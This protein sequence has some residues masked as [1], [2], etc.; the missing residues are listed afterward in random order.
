MPSPLSRKRGSA[1]KPGLNRQRNFQPALKTVKSLVDD[2]ADSEDPEDRDFKTKVLEQTSQS[3][4]R[5]ETA[6]TNTS[7]GHESA[8]KNRLQTISSDSYFQKDRLLHSFD[9]DSESQNNEDSFSEE[10]TESRVLTEVERLEEVQAVLEERIKQ[11]KELLE[12]ADSTRNQRLHGQRKLRRLGLKVQKLEQ[13]LELERAGKCGWT[14]VRRVLRK[15][16]VGFHS[17]E[18]LNRKV[19]LGLIA[20][21]IDTRP[22]LTDVVLQEME[23]KA[24]V[25]V[26][27]NS[28][29]PKKLFKSKDLQEFQQ[30]LSDNQSQ[31]GNNVEEGGKE[32]DNAVLRGE[33]AKDAA[34]GWLQIDSSEELQEKEQRSDRKEMEKGWLRISDK[35]GDFVKRIEDASDTKQFKEAWVNINEQGRERFAR[36][37]FRANMNGDSLLSLTLDGSGGTLN[38]RGEKLSIDGRRSFNTSQQ[39][40]LDRKDKSK[41]GR[42]GRISSS[43]S[44]PT[45]KIVKIQNV[46]GTTSFLPPIPK[47]EA[48]KRPKEEQV[49]KVKDENDGEQQKE[50][51]LL[52]PNQ[53]RLAR[54]RIEIYLKQL[55]F[56]KSHRLDQREI[57]KTLASAV[58]DYY[59]EK[60][61]PTKHEAKTTPR[62]ALYLIGA[63][64]KNHLRPPTAPSK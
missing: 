3:P 31:Q 53:R 63:L 17:S 54:R 24:D 12:T 21:N 43:R 57:L 28:Q 61:I 59:G 38:V 48:K 10:Q 49:E 14:F 47:S 25:Q 35:P 2:I 39:T 36:K 44:L 6:C 42:V 51:V 7:Q 1:K 40:R 62:H 41:E 46:A 58:E 18:L 45:A 32:P 56:V 33:V 9:S 19:P 23:H 20:A 16:K 60:G 26:D 4:T 15:P 8:S 37:V 30:N 11:T 29:R 34:S 50:R 13:R 22:H 52:I 5:N 64:S 27:I 55:E